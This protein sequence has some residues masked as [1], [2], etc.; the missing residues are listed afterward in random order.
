MSKKMQI[1]VANILVSSLSIVLIGLLVFS[2]ASDIIR[3]QIESA[4]LSTL[5]GTRD[6][7]ENYFTK[8][9][10]SAVQ[11]EKIPDFERWSNQPEGHSANHFDVLSLVQLL[12]RVQ[13]SHDYVDNVV[14]YDPRDKSQISSQP[15]LGDYNMGYVP[16]FDEFAGMNADYAFLTKTT[17][18]AS[19]YVYIRKLP[20][21]ISG[22]SS[23]LLFHINSKLF[24]DYLGISDDNKSQLGTAFIMDKQGSP[25]GKGTFAG[26]EDM[27]RTIA[28]EQETSPLSME[29][30]QTL[31]KNGMLITCVPSP[32]TG[33]IFGLAVTDKQYLSKIITL[34]NMTLLIVA[35]AVALAVLAAVASNHMFFRGWNKII[36]LIDESSGGKSP[37][38][39]R[40]DKFEKIYSHMFQLKNRLREMI[41][42]AKEAYVRK[43]LE[44]GVVTKKDWTE[45]LGLPLREDASFCCFA[46]EIDYYNQLKETYSEWDLFYFGYG[47][48]CVI[49]EVL[50]DSGFAV[51]LND[52]KLAG[53]ICLEERGESSWRE[54]TDQKLR[55]IH[56]FIAENFPITVSIGV[57]RPRQGMHQLHLA[58]AEA[59]E[60]LKQT[61]ASGTNTVLYYEELSDMKGSA[62]SFDESRRIEHDWIQSIRSRNKEEALLA[63]N[64]LRALALEQ[65][66]RKL[67]HLLIDFTLSLHR[68]VGPEMSRPLEAPTLSKLLDLSTLEEWLSWLRNQTERFIDRL[69][70]EYRGQMEQAAA[71]IKN[72]LVARLQ[73]DIRLE[74][75]CKPLGIPVSVAKQ[76]LKEVYETTFAE[77]LLKERIEKSKEWLRETDI[78]VEEI[79]KRLYY[80]NAQSFTRTFK[81]MTGM[82]PGQYRK[83]AEH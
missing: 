13:A 52:G 72:H 23:Y 6:H 11:M 79:A 54:Q 60:A 27:T 75:C 62:F 58:S 74:D 40:A 44:T 39:P 10:Q 49:R 8:L 32:M 3:E 5:K 15:T 57:S 83:L 41:P 12:V 46:V 21:F 70:E 48:A 18:G 61:F 65:D 2:Q 43:V 55:T 76:A 24:Y 51:K 9:N 68:N 53:V 73:E 64:R 82:P 16:F 63:L 45:Q 7:F 50:A 19:T 28:K 31:N 17:D 77:L 29:T 30:P 26:L 59:L 37:A 81:K 22:P 67:Q 4:H 47:I 34:R 69:S 33:W 25:I 36:R 66:Y 78:G 80:S 35:A 56:H 38:Q 14:L 42:E 20:I 1:A 71:K